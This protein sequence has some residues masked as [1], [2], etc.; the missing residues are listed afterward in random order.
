MHPLNM[1]F[2]SISPRILTTTALCLAAVGLSSCRF[3]SIKPQQEMVAYIYQDCRIDKHVSFTRGKQHPKEIQEWIQYNNGKLYHW[4]LA[5]YV[6]K[7][8]LICP[9]IDVTFYSDSVQMGTF[10]RSATEKDK[11]FMDWLKNQPADARC[12]RCK[13]ERYISAYDTWRICP[14]CNGIGRVYTY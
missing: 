1:K 9:G 2:R 6:P 5:E 11:L 8:V 7:I 14:H 13:G 4:T 3:P 12:P 10:I